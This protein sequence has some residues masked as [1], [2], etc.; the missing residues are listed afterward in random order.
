MPTEE[1]NCGTCAF[2]YQQTGACKRYPPVAVV[3]QK[4]FLVAF[5]VVKKEE[6]CGDW[7]KK[8]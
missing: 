2:W 1:T 4:G 6:W 5:P 8:K 7:E 3:D